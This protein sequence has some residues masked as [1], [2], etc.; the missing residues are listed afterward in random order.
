MVCGSVWICRISVFGPPGSETVSQ[1]YGY[2]HHQAKI[3]FK[4]KLEKS[5][6]NSLR[7]FI[8]EE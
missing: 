6:V 1:R 5:F 3:V 8:F 4:T 2:L 7:L